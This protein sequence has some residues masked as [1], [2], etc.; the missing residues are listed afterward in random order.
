MLTDEAFRAWCQHNQIA[1]ET[2]TYIQRIRSSPPVRKVRSGVSNVTGRYPSV[3]MG[4][5]IQFESRH[6]ELWGIYTMERDDNVLEYFDQPTRIQLHYQARSGRKTS[7]WHTPDFF[8]VRRDGAG[9]EE[10]KPAAVLD[11]LGI[12]MPER[13]QRHGAG[14]WQCP[15]GEAV[16]NALGLYYRVRTSAEYHPFYIQNL[17]LLQDFW[18]H[19]CHVDAG[20]EAQVLEALAVYPGVSVAAL[21]DAHPR[22]SVDVVWAMLTSR[23]L[24]TDVAAASLMDWDHVFLYQSE[25]E[26]HAASRHAVQVRLATPLASRLL[27]DGRLWEA[28]VEGTAVTL[29]PEVGAMFR[30]AYDISSASW[31]WDRSRQRARPRP[32]RCMSRHAK[33]SRMPG[34]KRWTPRIADGARSW[35]THGAK[36]SRSQRAVSKTGW[37]LFAVRK[38]RPDVATWDSW[39][40]WR[41]VAIAPRVS[42]MPPGSCSRSI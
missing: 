32:H 4:C 8:V 18:T 19:T 38:P 11:Q 39:I 36:R 5:A 25:A 3:K 33:P 9:F 26:G 12:R 30:L 41:D 23:R 21:L 10:W 42:R 40:T 13:Y 22:L 2:A 16:A 7:P 35:R 6:V 34:P 14:G 20:Q 24:Y 15:P 27:W 1:M 28:E 31:I 29:R 37:R 17:K